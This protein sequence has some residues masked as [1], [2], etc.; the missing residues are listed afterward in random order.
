MAS[1]SRDVLSQNAAR[2]ARL[3]K[4]EGCFREMPAVSGIL[5]K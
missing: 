3:V 4:E 5:C 1:Q 2:L